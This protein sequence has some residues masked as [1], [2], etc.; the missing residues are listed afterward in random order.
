MTKKYMKWVVPSIAHRSVPMNYDTNKLNLR[1]EKAKEQYNLYTTLP[2]AYPPN[3]QW[4]LKHKEE[5]ITYTEEFLFSI[6]GL[7]K[8]AYNP[9]VHPLKNR[10]IRRIPYSTINPQKKNDIVWIKLTN[11]GIISV[12]GTGC[13]IHFTEH[14]QTHTSAGRINKIL[15]NY[16]KCDITWNE[17]EV[18]IFPLI[19]IPEELNNSDIESGVGNYLISKGIPILDFYSHN[20]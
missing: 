17:D 10:K 7:K 5:I 3:E 15:S 14:A 20:Y 1:I 11:L 18:L 16:Y 8:P 2:N 6:I 9:I 19:E 4:K 13:D 12:I